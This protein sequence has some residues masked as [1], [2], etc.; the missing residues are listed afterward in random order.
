MASCLHVAVAALSNAVLFFVM[1]SVVG[2]G[3]FGGG[4]LFAERVIDARAAAGALRHPKCEASA[5]A[6]LTCATMLHSG[7]DTPA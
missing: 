6:L 5:E 1:P 4:Y 2:G 7:S 3:R